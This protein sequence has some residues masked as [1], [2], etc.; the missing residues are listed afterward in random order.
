[1]ASINDTPNQSIQKELI[2]LNLD[3]DQKLPLTAS[4]KVLIA[5]WNLRKFGK[6]TEEWVDIPNTSPKRN[7]HALRCIIEIL[8]RFDIIAVQEVTGNLKC[9][10]DTMRFLGDGWSFLMTDE[11]KGTKGNKERLAFIFNNSRV[12]L[13]GLACEIVIPDEEL[14]KGSIKNDALTRQFARTPYAVSFK[15]KDKTFVLL[16]LHVLFGVKPE[17]RKPELL[18]IANWIKDWAKELS[19]WGHSLIIL[20]DFNIDRRKDENFRAFTSTGLEVPQELQD[21]SRSIFD[22]MAFYDQIAWYKENFNLTYITGGSYDFTKIAMK[23]LN[24]SL[25]DLSFRISDHMPLYVEYGLTP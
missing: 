17:D 19:G 21:A 22:K 20:G 5:T 23:S 9:L 16:T 8:K 2:D 7:L 18:A 4:D 10:R 1:M 11:T 14:D 25:N 15:A 13:S 6:L 3:L 12:K 24:I